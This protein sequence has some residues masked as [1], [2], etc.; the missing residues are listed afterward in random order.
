MPWRPSSGTRA[1]VLA[2]LGDLIDFVCTINEPQMVALHGY[3]E[4]YHPPGVTNPTLWKRVGRV[5]LEAH[6]R[7]VAATRELSSA[8]PGPGRAAAAAR[9][10]RATTR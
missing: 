4:G 8:S 7:A 9:A 1:A 3:L 10:R 2:A 6:H 5:L